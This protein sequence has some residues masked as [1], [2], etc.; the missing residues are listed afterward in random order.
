MTSP[1]RP[2]DRPVMAVQQVF[3]SLT[4]IRAANALSVKLKQP[5]E[6]RFVGVRHVDLVRYAPQERLVHQVPRVEV[7]GE[8]NQLLERHL[9]LL[10]GGERQ[11][12]VTFFQRDDPAIEQLQVIDALTAEVINQERAAIALEL[13]RRFADVAPRV[14]A[15]LQAV[16]GKFAADDDR[17]SANLDPA[18]V[19]PFVAQEAPLRTVDRARGRQDRR[20]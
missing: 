12:V 11:E 6:F 8:D 15:D 5:M 3:D 16:Q 14:V 13:Q 19:D 20:T 2:P 1:E 7:G 4:V 10:A 17:R 18:I 9:D